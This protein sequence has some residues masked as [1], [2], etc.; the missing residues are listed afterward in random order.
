MAE[1]EI[2]QNTGKTV[3]K[4]TGI[5][6]LLFGF[7]MTDAGYLTMLIIA[8]FIIPFTSNGILT[9]EYAF[10]EILNRCIISFLIFQ[11]IYFLHYE[12]LRPFVTFALFIGILVFLPKQIVEFIRFVKN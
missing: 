6:A 7:L 8:S 1:T 2:N 3:T 5:M 12:P 10:F 11:L 9:S 4:P